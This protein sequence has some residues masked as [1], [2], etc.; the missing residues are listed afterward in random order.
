[1]RRPH[2]DFEGSVLAFWAG[3]AYLIAC[4]VRY[5]ASPVPCGVEGRSRW[6]PRRSA[7][8]RGRNPAPV[9]R[10][11]QTSECDIMLATIRRLFAGRPAPAF[12]DPRVT[13]A[14]LTF[15]R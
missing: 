11:G 15:G 2:G 6:G 9:G 8:V 5:D 1:M 10:S 12:T 4:A 14:L 3:I 7:P 13:A